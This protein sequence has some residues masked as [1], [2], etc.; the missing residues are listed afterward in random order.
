MELK[1]L[2]KEEQQFFQG[3]AKGKE[4]RQ[5]VVF[6]WKLPPGHVTGTCEVDPIACD[7]LATQSMTETKVGS[8]TPRSGVHC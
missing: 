3:S 7:I 2:E 5:C 6:A 1:V 8:S 4:P